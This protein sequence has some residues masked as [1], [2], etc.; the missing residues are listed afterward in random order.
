MPT[1]KEEVTPEE[2]V[3]EN[4]P[5]SEVSKDTAWTKAQDKKE[6]TEQ[7]QK[8]RMFYPPGIRHVL[9]RAIEMDMPTLL[10]GDT[11]TGKT[12]FIR[13]LARERGVELIRLNL[14]GQTGVDELVGKH[15]VRAKEV[16]DPVTKVMTV[17]SETY[18]VNG[19]LIEAMEN[20]FWLVLDEVNM[21][22]PEILA[23]LHSLLDDDKKIF[24]P[25]KNNTVV[26]P[27]GY[28]RVFATMNPS[29]EYTGTKELNKAFLSRFPV[30][31]NVDYSDNEMDIVVDRTG[32][33]AKI[34]AQLV[35]LAQQI[36]AGK[37][38]D[39]L[40]YTCSTRDLIYCA[41]LIVG[42]VDTKHAVEYALLNKAPM[43]ERPGLQKI[44]TVV[45]GREILFEDNG[46]KYTG[47][48]EILKEFKNS[49]KIMK[50]LKEKKELAENK[51]VK[52]EQENEKLKTK[53]IDLEKKLS[54]S[55]KREEE[56]RE[57]LHSV[58]ELIPDQK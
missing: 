51:L 45:M 8:Q 17:V 35:M 53:N 49:A 10:V 38:K 14:T 1:K 5:V 18:W 2:V 54:L 3:G 19:P 30:V 26:R 33:D 46:K 32:V 23:K 43:E 48:E 27:K 28:F 25:E 16:I 56:L 22:L 4:Q 41:Q 42:G 21:A 6:S 31:V 47:L 29:D 40:T 39:N 7:V 20:G 34:A 13:E 24:L 55:T 36:R 58:L 9:E 57:K 11:G 44:V 15:L 12:S 50:D 37:Q 52:S